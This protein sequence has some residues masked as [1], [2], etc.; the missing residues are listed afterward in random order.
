[1]VHT[2]KQQE[3]ECYS[4]MLQVSDKNLTQK[5]I[6]VVS[7][8]DSDNKFAIY[9]TICAALASIGANYIQ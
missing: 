9:K 6:A 7:F 5:I 1:M 3:G 8:I 2:P 4:L